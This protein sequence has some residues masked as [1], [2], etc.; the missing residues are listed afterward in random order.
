MCVW[1][2]GLSVQLL[3]ARYNRILPDYTPY[4]PTS[5]WFS[6]KVET[7]V[8]LIRGSLDA[9]IHA[10]C[11]TIDRC[12]RGT[13]TEGGHSDRSFTTHHVLCV[14]VSLVPF[15]RSFLGFLVVLLFTTRVR[16][17]MPQRLLPT[18]QCRGFPSL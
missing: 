14:S 2:G 1:G 16:P 7:P 9:A 10:S 4:A 6:K 15:A 13:A 3:A 5:S 8:A 18:R 11:R 12:A 17:W